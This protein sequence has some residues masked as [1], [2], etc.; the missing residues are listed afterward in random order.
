MYSQDSLQRSVPNGVSGYPL[1]TGVAT[2]AEDARASREP[3]ISIAS[4]DV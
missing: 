1:V 4:I 2:A 3:C